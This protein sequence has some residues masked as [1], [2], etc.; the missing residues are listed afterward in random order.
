[1]CFQ[2][3]ESILDLE[4]SDFEVSFLCGVGFWVCE[5]FGVERNILVIVCSCWFFILIF[6]DSYCNAG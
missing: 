6:Y 2:Y 5:F 3:V 4:I 1:M